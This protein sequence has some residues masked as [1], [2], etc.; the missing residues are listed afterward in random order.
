MNL[1]GCHTRRGR[2]LLGGICSLLLCFSRKDDAM[3]HL[4][5][6]FSEFL[7][8]RIV[9][10]LKNIL[11]QHHQAPASSRMPPSH[12]HGG[13]VG[14]RPPPFNTISLRRCDVHDTMLSAARHALLAAGTASNRRRLFL[15]W[16]PTVPPVTP[17]ASCSSRRSFS[18]C[19][20]LLPILKQNNSSTVTERHL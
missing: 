13:R 18:R 6:N 20:C 5:R 11:A 14:K 16:N 12:D 1:G 7:L 4:C 2:D 8:K 3:P 9:L 15:P 17:A 19:A 10:F